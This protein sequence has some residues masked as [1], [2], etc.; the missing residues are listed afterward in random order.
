M[1]NGYDKTTLSD[2]VGHEPQNGVTQVK[3]QRKLKGSEG[4]LIPTPGCNRNF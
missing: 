2:A 4:F 1:F 3:D